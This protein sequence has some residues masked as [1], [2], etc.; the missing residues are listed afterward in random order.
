MLYCG[1]RSSA[2]SSSGCIARRDG[3]DSLVEFSASER[4][5]GIE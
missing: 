2:R 1:E 3:I 5:G 4:C